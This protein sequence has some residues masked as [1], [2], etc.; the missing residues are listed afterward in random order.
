MSEFAKLLRRI[1]DPNGPCGMTR[2]EWATVLSVTDSTITRW[3]EDG[4]FPSPESMRRVYRT[5]EEDPSAQALFE[6]FK[7]VAA[8]PFHKI[9]P[10]ATGT[11][12]TLAHFMVR[13]IKE[14]FLSTLDTLRP[15]QQEAV[16]IEASAL[17][18]MARMRRSG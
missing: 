6:D 1:F 2:H 7:A 4:S 10:I 5:L 16:L 18:T 17:A 12:P 11:Y 8:K 14:A 9:S 3:A 15:D 13:P